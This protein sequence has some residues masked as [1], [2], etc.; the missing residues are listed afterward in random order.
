VKT[1]RSKI[2]LCM[3][4]TLLLS[5]LIVG[6]ITMIFNYRSTITTLE[7]TLMET[8]KITAE[9]VEQELTSYT[10]VCNDVGSLPE[11]SDPNVPVSQKEELIASR[12]SFF[13]FTRGNLLDANGISVITGQ[14]FSDRDYFHTSMTGKACVSEPIISKV[15][16][17]LSII[18]SAPLWKDGNPG[19]EVVGVV[20]FVPTE[21]FLNDIMA[22]IEVGKEGSAFMINKQGTTIA[23][24]TVENV[25]RGENTIEEAKTDSSL[26][27]LAELKK[28]MIAGKTG[29]GLYQYQGREKLL[30]YAPVG[31]TD[32]WSI[33]VTAPLSEFLTSTYMGLLVTVIAILV[34]GAV[35]VF[36]AWRLAASIGTPIA[37]CAQRLEALS[38]GELEAPVPDFH[39]KDE[40][41]TLVRSTKQLRD[42]LSTV[43]GDMDYLLEHMSSGDFTVHSR[44]P[45][46]Y[47]GNFHSLLE[48]EL[49]L[50]EELIQTLQEIDS[51]SNQ[52][53]SGA[54]QVSSGAQALAQGATEQASAVE[55]LAA[56]INDISTHINSNAE[57]TK[58]AEEE[59]QRTHDQ[60]ERCSNEME[61]LVSAIQVINDKSSEIS[62]IIKTIEDIAFQTNILALNAAV[63]AAR[64]GS[65]GKGFAVVAD[66]VRNLASKSQEA[67]KGTTVLIQE[68][69][70][71]VEK[72]TALSN[73][74]EESLRE[75]VQSAKAVLEAVSQISKA[76]N[77]QAT[78][79]SQ[80]SIGI[81]QIS[82]VVQTNSATAE[83]SAA[84]SE[85]LSSQAQVLK[86]MVGRFQLPKE[87]G[88]TARQ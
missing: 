85:E 78:S 39:A 46:S 64:A 44:A 20:Y 14:D 54:D 3:T 53:A 71:A 59:N 83:E 22:S 36:I 76:S 30:T 70:S 45:D 43:I 10:N 16:G 37:A 11:L 19:G 42:C 72:G 41:G 55:E 81:D 24:I 13:G 28:Q 51:T 25:M 33:A 8:A 38:Q 52:V 79:V 32:G 6:V 47:V 18:I 65:A 7:Q 1:I 69:V 63:E 35:S 49:C 80:V 67:A 66:E 15:T 40:T 56:S 86:D 27:R 23:S 74:T 26:E 62:K 21:T 84:A 17:D 48:A 5:L 87:A 82:S 50:K 29:Y 77:E 57:Y 31:N 34:S 60:I 2:M 12:A 61:E 75:V 58:T 88:E 73:Q 9:R 4:S 68:T